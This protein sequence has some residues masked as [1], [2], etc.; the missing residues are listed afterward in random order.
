MFDY[1]YYGNNVLSMK[2][3]MVLEELLLKE[4]AVRKV[5]TVRFWNVPKDAVV[6]GYAQATDAVKKTDSSFDL[7]RRITGG[8]HVQFG[9]NCFAYSFTVPRDGSFRNFEDMRKYFAEKVG[10]AFSN[11]GVESLKVDNGA[12]TINVDNKVVASHAI[13]WGVQSAL[14]HGLIIVDDYDVDKIFQRVFLQ[15]RKIG[16]KIYSEYSALKNIPA[17]SRLLE[18]HVKS[19][20]KEYKSKVVKKKLAGEMLKEVTNGRHANRAVDE[21]ILAKANNLVSKTHV[22]ERWLSLRKPPFTEKEIEE[23]PGSMPLDAPLKKD[24][25]YC[26][27]I[28]VKNKDF[29]KM[30]DYL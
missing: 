13:I 18:E 15:Q 11:L 1:E 6:L 21:P 23:I 26:L 4:S 29:K 3:N 27:Y 8:S 24:L 30:A 14:L 17:M 2:D 9:P 16:G 25:G 10:N 5:A 7:A 19:L 28:E 12:S 22:G 20:P